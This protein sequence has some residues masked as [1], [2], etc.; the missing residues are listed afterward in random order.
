MKQSV[1]QEARQDSEFCKYMKMSRLSS[2]GFNQL[3]FVAK[4]CKTQKIGKHNREGL[5]VISSGDREVWRYI[6]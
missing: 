2:E 3:Y 1:E 5:F 6:V 4:E